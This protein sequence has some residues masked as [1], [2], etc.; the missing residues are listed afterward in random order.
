MS[1]TGITFKDLIGA[2]V[3]ESKKGTFRWHV[4][5]VLGLDIGGVRFGAVLTGPYRKR[6]EDANADLAQLLR[7]IGEQK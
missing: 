7:V 6:L 1:K 2:H 3:V 4:A 5:A